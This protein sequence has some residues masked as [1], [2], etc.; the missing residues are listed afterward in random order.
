MEEIIRFNTFHTVK[1]L[2]NHKNSPFITYFY[3]F[4]PTTKEISMKNDKDLAQN[5]EN[6]QK[7]TSQSS[8]QENITISVPN[9]KIYVSKVQDRLKSTKFFQKTLKSQVIFVFLLVFF[10]INVVMTASNVK[11]KQTNKK[12]NEDNLTIYEMIEVLNI[13]RKVDGRQIKYLESVL[14]ENNVY[15]SPMYS[16]YISD[17]VYEEYKETIDQFHKIDYNAVLDQFLNENYNEQLYEKRQQ[18]IKNAYKE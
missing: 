1:L 12:S 14:E 2:K 8:S 11:I 7:S 16:S 9:P 10:I 17:E 5:Q 18:E 13:A 15:I 6:Q 4:I 3:P